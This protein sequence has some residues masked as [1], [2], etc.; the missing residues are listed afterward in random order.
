LEDDF[1]FN[2]DI[3]KINIIKDIE[4]FIKNTDFNLLYLGVLGFGLA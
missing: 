4:N 3:K 2:E 1:I